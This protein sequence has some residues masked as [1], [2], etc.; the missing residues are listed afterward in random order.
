MSSASDSQHVQGTQ[1]N[2]TVTVAL[3]THLKTMAMMAVNMGGKRV[4]G[5]GMDIRVYV[6]E[7][8]EEREKRV[9]GGLPVCVQCMG[10]EGS[11]SPP[12]PNIQSECLSSMTMTERVDSK[13]LTDS[14]SKNHCG[15]DWVSAKGHT[16]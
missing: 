14:G 16:K 7:G 13:L 12:S 9:N 3:Y 5:P 15:L 4:R 6:E 11:R 10:G 1:Q 8:R 2:P